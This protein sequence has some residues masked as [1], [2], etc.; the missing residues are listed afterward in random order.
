M[1][2]RGASASVSLYR[3]SHMTIPTKIRPLMECLQL[4]QEEAK[5]EQEE[6][7]DSTDV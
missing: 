3:R 7:N 4:I 6:K 1:C 2:H 5:V